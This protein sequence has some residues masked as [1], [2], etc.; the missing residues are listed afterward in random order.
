[1][2]MVGEERREGKR[3]WPAFPGDRTVKQHPH[4]RLR[5]QVKEGRKGMGFVKQ[6]KRLRIRKGRTIW[7][8]RSNGIQRMSLRRDQQRVQAA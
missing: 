8:T 1:M 6:G 3:L 4:V 2:L 7:M 5:V